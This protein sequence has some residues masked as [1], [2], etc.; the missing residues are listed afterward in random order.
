M[1][2]PP[3]RRGRGVSGASAS[4]PISVVMKVTPSLHSECIE[5]GCHAGNPPEVTPTPRRSR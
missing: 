1:G 5:E 2:L 4:C 3:L